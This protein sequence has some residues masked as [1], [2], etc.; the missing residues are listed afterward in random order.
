MRI[1]LASASP[2]RH[3]WLKARPWVQS[4]D[5]TVV[6]LN[7]DESKVMDISDVSRTVEMVI[8]LKI[9]SARMLLDENGG[10]WVGIVSDTMVEDPIRRIPMGKPRDSNQAREMLTTLSGKSHKIWTCTGILLPRDE[11]NMIYTESADVHFRDLD[12]DTLDSLVE[13]GSWIGKAG[14]YDIHGRASKL[15]KVVK[16]SE[17][18]VLGLSKNSMMALQE[19]LENNATS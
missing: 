16:G 8:G 14:G 2:R 19:I 9:E 10:D 11:G 18:T 4:H 5:I 12:A 6:P 1:F 7:V 13:S 17:I 15:V 3:V